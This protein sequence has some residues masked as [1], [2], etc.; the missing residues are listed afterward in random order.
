M[1]QRPGFFRR[2]LIPTGAA[3][4]LLTWGAAAFAEMPPVPRPRPAEPGAAD[5]QNGR[6]PAPLLPVE[7]TAGEPRLPRVR[8]V[9][10]A[11]A[12]SAPAQ[13]PPAAIGPEIKAPAVPPG[14]LTSIAGELLSPTLPVAA[15]A[16]KICC[17][18]RPKAHPV[19][20]RLWRR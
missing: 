13:T 19:R 9:L 7:E 15:A 4:L 2:A 10:G 17:H 12:G 11:A 16:I 8:P 1:S 3:L 20:P 5:F 6:S 14:Q 18:L